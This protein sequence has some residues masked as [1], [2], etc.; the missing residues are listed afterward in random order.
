[1]S[2]PTWSTRASTSL[3]RTLSAASGS[4][5]RRSKVRRAPEPPYTD[6]NPH[7]R[8]GR[9]VRPAVVSAPIDNP[10]SDDLAQALSRLTGWL[11]PRL[12][13]DPELRDAL[14]GLARAAAGWLVSLQ[15]ATP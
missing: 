2:C 8:A 13:D 9:C 12:R 1:M 15:P 10:M 11:A 3:P 5:S 7:R 6:G 14:A 4:C